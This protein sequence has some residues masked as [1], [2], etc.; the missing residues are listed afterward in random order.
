MDLK[1]HPL[2]INFKFL[3]QR[4]D[5]PVADKTKWSY[6]I[7]EHAKLEFHS[8]FLRFIYRVWLSCLAFVS[9]FRVWLSCL[10]FVSGFRVWPSCLAFMSGLHV[11]PSSLAFLSGLH[12]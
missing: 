1:A 2:I 3:F 9:G 6:V 11:W 10:A 4:F 8:L 5:N 12:A 7:R